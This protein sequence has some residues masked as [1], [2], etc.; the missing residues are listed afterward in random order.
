MRQAGNIVEYRQCGRRLLFLRLSDGSL[1]PKSLWLRYADTDT[2]RRSVLSRCANTGN[3][4]TS[5]ANDRDFFC[6]GV[7]TRKGDAARSGIAVAVLHVPDV[8]EEASQ[9]G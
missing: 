7:G 4:G 3:G 2:A 5:E 9:V 8:P 1:L 6:A